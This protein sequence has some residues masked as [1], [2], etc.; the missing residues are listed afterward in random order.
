M[1]TKTEKIKMQTNFDGLIKLLAKNLYSEPDVFVRELVQNAH[2][3]IQLRCK[4]D[5]GLEGR[6]EIEYDAYKHTITF[7]D[8]G[9]GMNRNDVKDFL[10][11]IGSSGTGKEREHLSSEGEGIAYELIGQFGIGM[12]SAFVVAEKIIVRTLR[13]GATESIIWENTGSED[14]LIYPAKTQLPVGT[15][16]VVHVR[17]EYYYM[18]D[19]K[20]L[21]DTIIKYCDLIPFE[22]Y[23]NG[24][25]PINTVDAPWHRDF[26]NSEEEKTDSYTRF[27]SRRYSDL[28]LDIIP[29]EIDE[30]YKARGVLYISVRHIPD[31]DTTGIIDIFVRRMFIRANDN[32]FLPPW[33][34]F[35]R[36]VIDSPD[37]QPTAARDN[38]RRDKAFEFFQKRL[39]ELIVARLIELSEKKPDTFK[40]INNWHHY[41]LKGMAFFHDDFFEKIAHKL[42]FETN[43]GKMS[44]EDYRT[45]NPDRE[46]N[47][48]KKTPIYYFAYQGAVTQFYK[49][50]DAKGWTVIN[51]GSA[52]EEELLEK[53][54]EKHNVIHLERLDIT[55]DK[56]L[57]QTPDE[58]EGKKFEKLEEDIEVILHRDSKGNIGDVK[59]KTRLFKP[60]G[61]PGVIILTPESEAEQRLKRLMS[62]PII[63][64]NIAEIA[65]QASQQ[66]RSRPV[67]LYLNASNPMINR[68]KELT[69]A[70]RSTPTVRE[71]LLGIYNSAILYS[72]NLLTEWNAEIIHGQFFWMMDR[73]M[74][75][76]VKG[77]AEC[78]KKLREKQAELEKERREK[79]EL[80]EQISKTDVSKPDY[81][82]LFM[83][84]PFNEAYNKVEEAVRRIFEQPPY[85]FEIRMDRDYTHTDVLLDNIR[86]NMAQSHG[87][88]AEIT[89]LNPNVMLELG[90]AMFPNDTRPVFLLRSESHE[91]EIAADLRTK[92]SKPQSELGEKSES[93]KKE[94]PADLKGKLF[95]PYKSPEEPVESI[96]KEIQSQFK[97][98]G[99]LKNEGIKFLLEQRKKHFLSS[100]FL[101]KLEDVNLKD[102]ELETLMK[103]YVT[104]EDLLKAESSDLPNMKSNKL[105]ALQ[106]ELE[107][108]I[109]NP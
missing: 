13:T 29:I 84:M 86:Q 36:G 9:I 8:N 58:K 17:K 109:N 40:Q 62:L 90:A 98:D 20:K 102:G 75:E 71:I 91:K 18:L 67:Y 43:N 47:G 42:I 37:L 3:S 59:V 34:K 70:D 50:A 10:S 27:L 99:R 24:K 92:V 52:F 7:R 39:G 97:K 16:V 85:C 77:H 65:Q 74:K 95:I 87:F 25:G 106:E 48:Q 66:K 100:I 5:K 63:S 60:E 89:D 68:L 78:E 101:K 41:H 76:V 104:V 35:I 94:I 32:A 1:D 55:N 14:C 93:H 44:L 45:K 80:K 72:H 88:I 38:V 69:E 26:W 21:K 73:L 108:K 49:L 107:S 82:R 23:L 105:K 83:I 57:F 6:I 46:Y 22:I 51:A 103:K 2:D 19:E 4:I 28:P 30:K 56:E 11:V 15:E 54:A 31:V 33:A 61:L 79:M 64:E 12:L 96:E 53:Y 81:I